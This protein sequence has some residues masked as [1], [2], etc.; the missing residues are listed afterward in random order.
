[1]KYLFA[2]ALLS[3]TTFAFSGDFNFVKSPENYK[4][5]LPKTDDEF[6][7]EIFSKNLIFYTRAEVP[8]CHQDTGGL[9]DSMHNISGNKSEPFGNANREFPWNVPA[10]TH[11][12]TGFSSFN[13][14][15][16]P[17]AILWEKVIM[18]RHIRGA[19]GRMDED[20]IKWEYP[21]GTIFGEVLLLQDGNR[22]LCF[23][24]RTRLKNNGKWNMNLYRPVLSRKELDL[25]LNI[26]VASTPEVVI[27]SLKNSNHL[28]TVIDT[29]A[30][31]DYLPE[32]SPEMVRKLLGLP[33]RSALGQEWIVKDGIEG[34]A[35]STKSNFSIVPKGYDAAH[36][37]IDSKFC[38]TC[39]EGTLKQADHFDP[40][41]DW[42]GR[43][44]GSD[45]IF[46]FHI[47]DPSCISKNGFHINPKF[48]QG[49]INAG[50]L[51]RK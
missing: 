40:R 34:F 16:L 35:P 46:S 48:N 49:L 6:L 10:G 13:F 17:G 25:H 2:L 22:L 4:K 38:M 9:Y 37:R 24:V 39:H 31:V 51:K 18:S 44:R 36:L 21:N 7:K 42:Y 29:K 26:D 28:T 30:A 20:V 32:M 3:L 5:L 33:F 19:D 43:V 50:L 45:G 23:E 27:E 41:R 47:F 12:A 8:I 1:M 15:Y 11:R 14:V